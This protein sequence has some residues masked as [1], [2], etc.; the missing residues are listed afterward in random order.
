MAPAKALSIA[1]RRTVLQDRMADEA[2][3]HADSIEPGRLERQQAE[4]A[5]EMP[6][7][8]MYAPGPPC[9]DCRC[10]IVD[11]SEEH[12]SELQSLMRISYAV[13]CLKKKKTLENTN[14]ITDQETQ[15]SETNKR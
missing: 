2:A 5:I 4:Q 15:Q 12:T 10:D 13:F 14:K 3:R 9:P 1:I 11:R 7:E 8:C 6:L